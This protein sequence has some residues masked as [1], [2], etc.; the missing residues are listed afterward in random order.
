MKIVIAGYGAV[1]KAIEYTLAPSDKLD[2]YID[3]PAQGYNY[4]R[5]ENIDPPDCVIVCVA[6]PEDKD[7]SCYTQN[8]EDVFEKYGNTKYLIKSAVD[9]VW[10]DWESSVRNGS[11]TY[12]PEFLG[13]SNMNRDTNMEFLNQEFAI[14][15]GDD[16]RFW[17]ELFKPFLPCLET[18]KYCSL[19]QAAFAKYVENTFLATKVAFFNEMRCIFEDIGFEG[20]DQ[21]VDAVTIDPR[22]GRSHTQVPGPDGMYGFGGHCL[23]KDINAMRNLY[24]IDQMDATKMYAEFGD[25]YEAEASP[26]P[27]LDAVVKVNKEHRCLSG[28]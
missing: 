20:F 13:S 18:V 3:D 5:D 10:L 24:T 7:G 12:S 17:D 14:Y 1:G 27:L 19:Q 22:I 21:M 8:V 26:T 15:G 6:T 11:F 16:P 28:E 23:P 2:V 25:D 4:Y 9:P